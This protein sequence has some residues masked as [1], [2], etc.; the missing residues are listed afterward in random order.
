MILRITK[1]I[2]VL[3]SLATLVLWNRMVVALESGNK[4]SIRSVDFKKFS[5]PLFPEAEEVAERMKSP[6]RVK[7]GRFEIQWQDSGF[8][9][10][11]FYVES[12]VF[13][14]ITGDGIEDAI[15]KATFSFMGAHQEDIDYLYIYTIADGKLVLLRVPDIGKQIHRD[16]SKYNVSRDP[17]CD[18]AVWTYSTKAI[19]KGLLELELLIGN[20]RHCFGEK[21]LNR[22]TIKYRLDNN[23]WVLAEPPRRW[24]AKR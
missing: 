16:Y 7:D 15:V 21:A 12:P 11:I 13:G 6:V 22:A 20:Q 3:A 24:R 10:E 19:K 2:L 23:R 4:N 9:E 17:P 1:I 5:Y 14:D 8:R 18:D